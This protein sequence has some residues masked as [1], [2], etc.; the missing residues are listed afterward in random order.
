VLGSVI[1]TMISRCVWMSDGV[2]VD[3]V[4]GLLIAAELLLSTEAYELFGVGA[5]WMAFAILLVS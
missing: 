1:F 4:I 3:N 5:D 2:C